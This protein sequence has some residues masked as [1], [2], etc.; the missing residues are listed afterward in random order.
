MVASTNVTAANGRMVLN[1]RG[2]A[3]LETGNSD[4]LNVLRNKCSRQRRPRARGE[5]HFAGSLHRILDRKHETLGRTRFELLH[6]RVANRGAARDDQRRFATSIV[7]QHVQWSISFPRRAHVNNA[8]LLTW[9]N[10]SWKE[11]AYR[12]ITGQPS[13]YDGV[14]TSNPQFQSRRAPDWTARA[15]LSE[16][17]PQEVRFR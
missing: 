12:F 7:Q 17:Q 10:G 15:R 8:R 9:A 2:T 4:P 16:L 13:M 3:R 11:C 5:R 1:G 6:S 14:Q